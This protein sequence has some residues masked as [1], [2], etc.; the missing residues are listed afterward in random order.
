M[1]NEPNKIKDVTLV[2]LQWSREEEAFIVLN[3]SCL[4]GY[5]IKR[6]EID[7]AIRDIND[8]GLFGEVGQSF[9]TADMSSV[10]RYKRVLSVDK[11]HLGVTWVSASLRRLA[12][13]ES[14]RYVV[15][16]NGFLHQPADT[17][18]KPLM[19]ALTE[20]GEKRTVTK[21]ITWDIGD[22]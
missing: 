11:A 8:D 15:I 2:D 20:V 3:D 4:K 22:N 7:R 17:L 1:T 5:L 21:I 6:D 19:R 18:H 14:G 9:L 10:E 13:Q 16:A 12:V